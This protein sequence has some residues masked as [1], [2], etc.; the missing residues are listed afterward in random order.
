MSNGTPLKRKASLDRTH[1]PEASQSAE[2]AESVS[3]STLAQ[4]HQ[5]GAEHVR[6]CAHHGCRLPFRSS[7]TN[8]P[9]FAAIPIATQSRHRE[10]AVSGA[11]AQAPRLPISRTS[12]GKS[13]GATRRRRTRAVGPALLASGL[14]P[15]S[16]SGEELRAASVS[17]ESMPTPSPRPNRHAS[18]HNP[19]AHVRSHGPP[20][21]S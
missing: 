14:G 4:A 17:S 6:A 11:C 15:R 8:R 2:L 5:H 19:L 13:S 3:C 18:A 21:L 9:P 10:R 16:I 1:Q 7:S 20:T 12:H